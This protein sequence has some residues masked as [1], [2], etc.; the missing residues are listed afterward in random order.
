[1]T[2]LPSRLRDERDTPMWAAYGLGLLLAIQPSDAGAV[3]LGVIAGLFIVFLVASRYRLGWWGIAGLVV[4]GIALRLG[5]PNH[6]A[7]DVLDVAS[8]AV[9][10]ALT[11]QNPYGHGYLISRPPGAHLATFA[12]IFRFRASPSAIRHGLKARR[13]WL[14][15]PKRMPFA[16]GA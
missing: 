11:G 2:W 4:A 16:S 8:E 12:A 13:P 7:S 6:R 15:L 10:Q 1:V 3:R 9:R 5:V 14:P